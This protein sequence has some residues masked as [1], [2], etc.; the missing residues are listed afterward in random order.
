MRGNEANQHLDDQQGTD[1][2][3]NKSHA[4]GDKRIGI[5]QVLVLPGIVGRGANDC[6]RQKGDQHNGGE[7]PAVGISFRY[8]D[9][10]LTN[11]LTVNLHHRQNGTKLDNDLEHPSFARGKID[12]AA[13]QDQMSRAGY[14][15][16]L[17]QTFNNPQKQCFQ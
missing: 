17:G 14:W 12:L 2:R 5:E 7:A 9:D 6:G 1:K 8:A 16:E 15:Q 10:E 13:N 4:D 3:G 11:S